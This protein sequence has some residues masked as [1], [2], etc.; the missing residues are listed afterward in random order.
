[1]SSQS[2]WRTPR[3][4]ALLLVGT[5]GL[6]GAIATLVARVYTDAL[7]F[8]EVGQP[9]VYWSALAWRV[10]P[11]AFTGLGTA[12]F[13]LANLA[14]AT[15]RRP[16]M[17]A[18]ALAAGLAVHKPHW[19]QLALWA[20][21]TDFGQRDPVFHRDAG[22]F[23]F[24]LPL[25]EQTA[26]W[27]LETVLI[28]AALTG[29]AHALER[30]LKRAERHLLALAALGLL[31]SAW[32]LHLDEFALALPHRGSVV[33]GAAYTD[34]HVRRPLLQIGCVLSLAAA[35][36]AAYA[37]FR[38]L[39]PGTLLVPG[40]IVAVAVAVAG[41]LPG[42]VEALAVS[43][44]PLARERPYVEAAIQATRH[45]YQL[46]G[47]KTRT[48]SGPGRLTE[49]TIADNAQAIANVPLWDRSVV[50]AALD[51]THAQGGYYSF[52]STT[53]DRYGDRLLTL[54][55]RRL[56]VGL[57][58]Q[59]SWANTRFAYTHGYG[60]TAVHGGETDPER[61]PRFQPVPVTQ[62]RI[63]FGERATLDPPY[64]I[65]N[66]RRAEVEQPS[67]NQPSYH[68]DGRGGIPIGNALT[69]A[70]F[71]IRFDDLDLWLT[72]TPTP[73]SRIAI[74]RDAR[75][76]ARTLAPFL[77]WDPTPQ[78]VVRDGR[79][80]FRFYGYTRS[81]HYPYAAP[82][83]G[84]N[85]LRASALAVV[86]AFDGRTTLHA[87]DP[88][89][90]ILAAWRKT[91]PTLFAPAISNDHYPGRLF[92]AQARVLETHHATEATAFWNGADAW[93]RARQ[94]AGPV[95]EAV[96]LHF[97]DDNRQALGRPTYLLTRLPGETQPHLQLT[98]AFTPRGRENLVG[99]LAGSRDGLTLLTFPRD[100]PATGPT[101]ATRQ[102][103]ATAGVDESLQLLNRESTDLGRASI[104]RAVL[105]A[106]KLVPI[107]DALVY[108]QPVYVTT[109][110]TGYPRLQLV[111]VH[112][113]GRVG[114]G[115]TLTAALAR[116]VPAALRS[117]R[118]SPPPRTRSRTARASAPSAP[119]AG[120]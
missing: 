67:P 101:Q 119:A 104:N 41:G 11:V 88:G 116:A 26:R 36:F 52:A 9:S 37:A 10:L 65:L 95:E 84:K 74:H 30:H 99:Y 58:D 4:R 75:E 60:V 16:L 56:D 78:T 42:L 12:C 62:P 93:N 29:V 5:L 70:A 117:A 33:P 48:L 73:A 50:R 47:L 14:R 53:V 34:V 89:D 96:H 54:G 55:A 115:A 77:D 72:R 71:A 110:G 114:Y 46:D 38:R 87:Q 85:Y 15:E 102:I 2:L 31:V 108:V 1:M 39:N 106:P 112:A 100:D 83:D 13:V 69:K 64:A 25:Y 92:R 8:G 61:Y 63:Y 17:L 113:N 66:S 103:L 40:L 118:R 6:L 57:L 97:P 35:G 43:P 32:R 94:L 24:N 19:E 22:F 120:R 20:H 45:A 98:A 59:A 105:G 82:V 28:T 23:V 107:G 18:A 49:Q 111:T 91:F 68:Y 109:A 21:R 79:V 90:P 80:Q 86:D 44:Q 76:R 81:D 7:W 3:T 27:L 51:E